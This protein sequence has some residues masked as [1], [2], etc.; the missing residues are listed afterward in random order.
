MRAS[1]EA[2]PRPSLV[3]HPPNTDATHGLRLGS[4]FGFGLATDSTHGALI[5]QPTESQFSL[6]TDPTPRV[7]LNF[8]NP[9]ADFS[10]LSTPLLHTYMHTYGQRHYTDVCAC[11]SDLARSKCIER[12]PCLGLVA[13]IASTPTKSITAITERTNTNQIN[14]RDNRTHQHQPNQ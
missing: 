6:S 8:S 1:S 7:T 3:A 11:N 5:L 14:N 2:E 12:T 4:G 10:V 9:F 13:D